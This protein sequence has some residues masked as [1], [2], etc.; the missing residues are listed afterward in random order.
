MAWGSVA[1]RYAKALLDIGIEQNTFDALNKELERAAKLF[2]DHRE[3]RTTLGSPV[4]PL[5]KRAEILN[6]LA[7]RL[8]LSKMTHNLLLLLLQRG[9]IAA[10]PDVA[11]AH[12]ALVDEH[13]GRIRGSVTSA[14]PLPDDVTERLKSA[15]EKASRK[16]VVLEKHQDPT[17]LGGIVTQLGDT[18]YDGSVRSRLQALKQELLEK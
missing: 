8:G 10:L 7:G 5:S 11:R 13:A 3:L 6:D 1:R 16:T 18:Q 15:L 17:L 14:G 9:R 2:G 12:Q 4:V